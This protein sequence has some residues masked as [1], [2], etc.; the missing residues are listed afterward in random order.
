MTSG[1]CVG[2]DFYGNN[3]WHFDDLVVPCWCA[4][5]NILVELLLC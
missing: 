3:V 1:T 5:L 2:E 4:H